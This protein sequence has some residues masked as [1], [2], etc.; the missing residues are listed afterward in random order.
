MT[1]GMR[2]LGS[3]VIAIAAVAQA[4]CGG[5]SGEQPTAS[6]QNF[7]SAEAAIAASAASYQSQVESF[8]GTMTISFGADGESFDTTGEMKF[9]SPDKVYLE[10]DLP[11]FGVMEILLDSDVIFFAIDGEWYRGNADDLGIDLEEFQQYAKDRGPVDYAEALEGLTDLVKLSDETIDGKTYW[12]YHAGLDLD[13]LS[14][15]LPAELIDPTLIEEAGDALSGTEMEIYI[16]PVTLL[17][18]RYT[19]EMSMDFGFTG[20]EPMPFTMTMQMDFEKYNE[21]VDMPDAP[22]DAKDFD[23][24]DLPGLDEDG[25]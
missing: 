22:E 16:D 14:N 19:M 10:M 5:G 24:G 9:E 18:R 23:L 25:Y 7:V 13:A 11:G 20:V 4:A 8:E 1:I 15:E 21:D 6:P 2:A 12:H 17:P 3:W